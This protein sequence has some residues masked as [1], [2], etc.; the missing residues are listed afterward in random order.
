VDL[1]TG[2]KGGFVYRVKCVDKGHSETA[3]LRRD[4]LGELRRDRKVNMR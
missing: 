4:S 3:G 2:A 1:R